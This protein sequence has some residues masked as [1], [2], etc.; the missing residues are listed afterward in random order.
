[1]CRVL[2][3]TVPSSHG[4]K[5]WSFYRR[6]LL[7]FQYKLSP[8]ME[9]QHA[10]FLH[11]PAVLNELADAARSLVAGLR[12][13]CSSLLTASVQ[14]QKCCFAKRSAPRSSPDGINRAS[15][16]QDPLSVLTLP[17][18]VVTASALC[19]SWQLETGCID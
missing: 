18:V 9:Q 10:I 12:E 6:R 16:C 17:L 4:G 7:L 5:K 14:G 13:C 3:K 1:M 8:N 2:F 19:R 15:Y 11:G